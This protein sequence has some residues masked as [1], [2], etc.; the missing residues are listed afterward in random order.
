MD[1]DAIPISVIF[2]GRII[3]VMASIELGHRLGLAMHRDDRRAPLD[4]R[5]DQ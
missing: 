1:V 5:R 2:A 3:V 4:L